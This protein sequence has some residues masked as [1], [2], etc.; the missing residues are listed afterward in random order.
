[1]C[2]CLLRIIAPLASH[3]DK[4]MHFGTS[5]YREMI[6]GIKMHKHF[7]RF[8]GQIPS[9]LK[10]VRSQKETGEQNVLKIAFNFSFIAAG[11][12]H[13]ASGIF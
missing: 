9:A 11:C 6:T 10:S 7:K 2:Q 4:T 12:M 3:I 5:G 8:T 1:M 13:W